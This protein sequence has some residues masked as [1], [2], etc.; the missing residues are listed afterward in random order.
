MNK[1]QENRISVVI[2]TYNAEQHLERVLQSV[3]G[4][5]EILVCDMESTDKTIAI[6][7]KHNC[8]IITF[9]KGDIS[10]VEPARQ[11]AI[12][13]ASYPWVLVVD[14]D[15]LI[16]PELKK[17]LYSIIQKA[18]CPD[19]VSIPRKNY[20]MGRFMHSTYPDYI[21]RFFKKEKV[22]WPPIIHTSPIVKGNIHK[23][24][25]NEKDKAFIHLANDTITD[26]IRKNNTYSNY[27]VI[28]RSNKKYSVAHLFLRPAFRVFKAYILKSGWKDGVPGLIYALLMGI[29]QFT[30][31]AKI[32]E[33][34]NIL[35][36]RRQ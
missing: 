2:N 1:K 26:I 24:P 30:I 25:R 31:V 8:K 35:S 5:D 17:H 9:P 11:F 28:R 10:I 13:A 20:F 23:I 22:Q 4:F 34:R 7:Q 3:D 14:A 29:Y 21:L 32:I 16:T 19:G 27:E 12:D 36:R 18:N 33:K 6:A 15:E